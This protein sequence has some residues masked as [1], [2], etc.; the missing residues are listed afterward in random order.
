MPHIVKK[1]VAS[2]SGTKSFQTE[3]EYYTLLELPRHLAFAQRKTALV[4]LLTNLAFLDRKLRLTGFS[5][6]LDDFAFAQP[7]FGPEDAL[8]MALQ[9]VAESLQRAAPF[10]TRTGRKAPPYFFSVSSTIPWSR[11]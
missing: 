2:G 11:R 1:I 8:G 6:L 3:C 9:V 4:G 7:L 10:L 5:A